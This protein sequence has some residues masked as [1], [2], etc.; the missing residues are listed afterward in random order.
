MFYRILLV[1]HHNVMGLN[2]VM[3][4]LVTLNL[5]VSLQNHHMSR[6]C[7]GTNLINL[8][9]NSLKYALILGL[10]ESPSNA[11]GELTTSYR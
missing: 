6:S 5:F 11:W 9:I 3:Y 10:H 8:G 1:P 4:N 2:N 7:N